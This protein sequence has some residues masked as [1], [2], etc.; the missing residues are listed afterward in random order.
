VIKN[1]LH[2][3]KHTEGKERLKKKEA[4]EKILLGSTMTLLI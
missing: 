3:T 4:K 2:S 1:H